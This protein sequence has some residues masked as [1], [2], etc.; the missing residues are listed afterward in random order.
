M[1]YRKLG[2]TDVMVSAVS[3]GCMSL[4]VDDEQMAIRVVHMALD[5]GINLL[6]TADLYQ[7]GRNEEVVGKAI[8]G[9]RERLFVS[10]KVGNEWKADGTWTWN[11]AKAYILKAA[12]ASLRRL[13]T[14]YID[15]YQMHG[16]TMED[17][18]QESL[19]AMLQLQSEGLIR[20]FGISSIRPNVI[21][22]WVTQSSLASVMVQYSLLDRRPEEQI[23]PLLAQEETGILLRGTLAQGLLVDKPAKDYLQ[24]D[25]GMV[26]D[27]QNQIRGLAG[28]RSMES[29][30]LSFA[31]QR[32]E[33]DS[34]V[35]GIRS[36]DQLNAM[37]A[38]AGDVLDP[39]LYMAL[40]EC[41]PAYTYE[42]H[43]IE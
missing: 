12:K 33:V 23:F 14:D 18:F 10:T 34:A 3:L 9:R 6:D 26:A 36:V 25:T 40:K 22:R 8:K 16:G 37:L 27:A 31:L 41:C 38:A 35:I 2:R 32:N 28:T 42:Q 17:P 1:K 30:A 21:Q 11:P 15:L 4:P 7:Q 29:L 39:D 20:Y 19:E 5:A 13:K 43:R 24:R